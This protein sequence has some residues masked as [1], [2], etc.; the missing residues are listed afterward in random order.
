[1][2]TF[3]NDKNAILNPPDF[4]KQVE[5]MPK[6]AVTCYAKD[7]FDRLIEGLEV[8]KL[9]KYSDANGEY[10]VYGTTYKG[11]DVA[12]FM[13][14]VGAA[15]SVGAIEDVYQ[16][17]CEKIIVFG[18][19]GVLDKNIEDCSIII[20]DSAVREEGVSYHYVP[21]KDEI[22]VNKKHMATFKTLLNELG[23]KYTV[24][25]TWTTDGFYR[26][27]AGKVKL[28]K[29]KGCVC[30]DMECSANS[31]VAQFREKELV[32]FFY[33]ADNLDNEEWDAR[34][35]SN[36]ARLEDKDKIA[37]I[38]LELAVRI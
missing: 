4:I 3:D 27:T 12:L 7:T 20:P 2:I 29:E 26:E 5:N 25:K 8:K 33:A 32:Q 22:E 14:R 23:V 17:G 19:C 6:V 16:M 38:A 10:P 9:S 1:M 34:S 35:L 11:V 13:I 18:T 15:G 28:M 37:A 31:A 21:A 30:V 24:G 36:S